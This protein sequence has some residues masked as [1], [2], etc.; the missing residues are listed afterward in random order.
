VVAQSVIPALGRLRWESCSLRLGLHS[1]TVSKKTEEHGSP[2][3]I[4]SCL[5]YLGAAASP[6][7]SLPADL[8]RALPLEKGTWFLVLFT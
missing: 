2:F 3:Q 8:L 7:L 5:Q 4:G 6:K 1:E